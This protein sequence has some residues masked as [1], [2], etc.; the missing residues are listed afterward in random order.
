MTDIPPCHHCG[1]TYDQVRH[2]IVGIGSFEKPVE[3]R[4]ICNECIALSM[5]ILASH[6]FADKEELISRLQA[7][8]PQNSN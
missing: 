4:V 1:K 8:E 2:L 3:Q 6:S 7:V 5:E